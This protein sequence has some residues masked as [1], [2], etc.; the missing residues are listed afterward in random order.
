MILG[1]PVV[2]LHA[3]TDF[4]GRLFE[5]PPDGRRLQIAHG[6]LDTSRED[7]RN[8]AH[9]LAPNA[10]WSCRIT[11]TSTVILIPAGH[12]LCVEIASTDFPEYARNLNTGKDRY[13]TSVTRIAWQTVF[14]GRQRPTALTLPVAAYD[15]APHG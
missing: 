5:L 14:Y 12:R 10:A 1:A 6:A 4:L 11:L 3:A 7:A 8:G 9:P 2:V 13:A 15:K